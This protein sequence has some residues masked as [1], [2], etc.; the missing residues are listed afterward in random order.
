MSDAS[1]IYGLVLA[2]GR[3]S[4]MGHDKSL[5]DYHGKSQREYLTE[6]LSIF[7]EKVF[8]S[9]KTTDGLPAH[10]HPLPD[11]FTIDSPLNGILSAF[12]H[13]HEVAWLTMPVD[14]PFVDEAVLRFLI[15]HRDQ[16]KAATCFYD[17]DGKEP[18]PLLAIWEATCNK[19]LFDYYK[20]GAISPR[21]F[22]KQQHINL[23]EAP[24][25][26]IHQNINTSEE[27]DR[28][29]DNKL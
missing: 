26:R 23:L 2:G 5:I 13:N 25:K 15:E 27:L 24:D 22:L 21:G 10:L 17:S 6:I 14:M 12:Q 3:S 4:R 9:C 8:V 20:M 18:E 7:C 28:Y 1:P 19:P 11:Q 29:R 16:T